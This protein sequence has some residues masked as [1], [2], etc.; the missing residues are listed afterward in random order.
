MWIT[1]NTFL[2]NFTLQRDL[3]IR[4]KHNILDLV[5]LFFSF[6]FFVIIVSLLLY[7][8]SLTSIA[9]VILYVPLYF[10]IIRFMRTL[11]LGGE[12]HS[13]SRV[14]SRYE[15]SDADI[16]KP[17]R[18][19]PFRIYRD[20]TV[21][22]FHWFWNEMKILSCI[23]LRYTWMLN[24]YCDEKADRRVI[25][26]TGRWFHNER[27]VYWRACAE[28]RTASEYRIC[29]S[30]EGMLDKCAFVNYLFYYLKATK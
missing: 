29:V 19:A 13:A 15:G 16:F 8:S 3:F 23:V 27:L 11:D 10:Y 12:L 2:R 20:H 25:D 30:W 21:I 14:H 24:N 6:F 22:A 4:C 7:C 17:R 1:P 9:T 26:G 28:H 18:P 5:I